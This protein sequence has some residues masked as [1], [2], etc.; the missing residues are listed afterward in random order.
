MYVCMHVCMHACM[1]TCIHVI[2]IKEKRA[3]ETIHEKRKKG[4]EV[5]GRK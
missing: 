3:M 4:L 5:K 1:Y 2:I